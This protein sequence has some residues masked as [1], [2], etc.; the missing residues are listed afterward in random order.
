MQSGR[1]NGSHYTCWP[2]RISD[3]LLGENIIQK[4]WYEPIFCEVHIYLHVYNLYTAQKI[5]M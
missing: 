4:V 1:C 3:I 2:G 5:W